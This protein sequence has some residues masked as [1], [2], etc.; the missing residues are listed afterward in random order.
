MSMGQ[1]Q[2][3]CVISSIKTIGVLGIGWTPVKRLHFEY[4]NLILSSV[5][6]MSP[7]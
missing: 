5:K 2:E 3:V 7:Y 6:V 4:V 1:Q